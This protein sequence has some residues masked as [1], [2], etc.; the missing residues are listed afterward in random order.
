MHT[1]LGKPIGVDMKEYEAPA[2]EVLGS[3]VE[4]TL[5]VQPGSF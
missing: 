5:S 1:V 4:E 2:V 3:V